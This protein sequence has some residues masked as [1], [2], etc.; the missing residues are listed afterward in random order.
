[1]IWQQYLYLILCHAVTSWLCLK[2]LPCV[3]IQTRT[4]SSGSD[5]FWWLE[6]FIDQN[7]LISLDKSVSSFLLSKQMIGAPCKMQPHWSWEHSNA[8]GDCIISAR[9]N[10][11]FADSRQ[12]H[13][14]NLSFLRARMHAAAR[15]RGQSHVLLALNNHPE[16]CWLSNGW[17]LMMDEC[18]KI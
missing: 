17:V 15:P 9:L 13:H 4:Y 11:W 6:G 7:S 18:Q 2:D 1:M 16:C 14:L 5:H 8:K 12:I 3:L 10:L